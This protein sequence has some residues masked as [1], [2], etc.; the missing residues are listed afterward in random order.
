MSYKITCTENDD[1]GKI[2]RIQTADENI[3]N[4][5]DA[6]ADVRDAVR[7]KWGT[8]A[9]CIDEGSDWTDS[10]G[11]SIGWEGSVRTEAE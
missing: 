9:E 8:G 10:S 11:R 2:V 6:M 5:D 4:D 7:S 1:D 3:L